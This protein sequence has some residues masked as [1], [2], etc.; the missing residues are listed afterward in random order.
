MAFSDAQ[1]I[2]KINDITVTVQRHAAAKTLRLRI[3]RLKKKP[4]VMA[5]KRLSL[6]KITAFVW[7]HQEWL[8]TQLAT[9]SKTNTHASEILF[10]G[11]N[12]QLVF[13]STSHK[14]LNVA[15]NHEQQLI[16]HN[17]DSDLIKVRLKPIFRREALQQLEKHCSDF[18]TRLEVS[19]KGIQIKDYKSRWGSCRQ[20][21]L[22]SFSWRLILAP[23][24]ILEYV[25]AHE[26]AHLVH[27]N[28]SPDF[29]RVVAALFPQYKQ[30][31]EWLKQNGS[32]L[33]QHF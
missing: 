31:R 23:P 27:L 18:A 26:V 21:G 8:I 2:I 22:L 25:G 7:Q 1:K 29:W 15:F 12:Y 20:D 24:F 16:C 11:K 3:D 10:Q 4:V 30:A 5:P 28:H 14:R 33:F 32:T 6:E 13:Q 17:M 19:F 9:F